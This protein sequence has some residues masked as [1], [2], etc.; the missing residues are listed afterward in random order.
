MTINQLK[1]WRVWC[2]NFAIKSLQ[3]RVTSLALKDETIGHQWVSVFDK[4][5]NSIG[6]VSSR[7]YNFAVS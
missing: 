2:P 1:I 7:H 5:R 3:W 6:N 4:F